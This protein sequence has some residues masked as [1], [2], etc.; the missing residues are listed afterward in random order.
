MRTVSAP[1]TKITLNLY[2]RD[3]E[4]FRKKYPQGYTEV[5]REVVRMHREYKE[6]YEDER[7][8]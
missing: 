5:I 8:Q 4:W 2:T 3:V 1:I 6:T 7:D